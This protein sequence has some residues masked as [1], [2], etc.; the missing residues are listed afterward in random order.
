MWPLQQPARGQVA[1]VGGL[2]TEAEAVLAPERAS[3]A[4]SFIGAFTVLLREGLEALLVVIAMIAF[5][6]K[7]E[8]L[9]EMPYV[10]GGWITALGV[11]LLT[12]AAATYVIGVS[13]ASREL[14]EGF[15]SLFAAVVLLSVGIWMHGKSQADNWQRY[16]REKMTNALS[17]RS[18]WFLFGLTF[19]VVYR[20]AFETIL[21]YAT[22]WSQGNRGSVL[23]GAGAAAAIL[24]AI[25][26]LMLRFSRTLPIAK[27][28]AYSSA[29]IAVLAVVLAGK[30]V[31]ALQEAGVIDVKPLVGI[32]RIAILGVF[33][34]IE[35]VF[36]QAATFAIIALAFW[37]NQRQAR[38][39]SRTSA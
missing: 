23:A 14:T 13:G 17:K 36:A 15:G 6:R 27:F 16:I 7:A 26:G 28:F 24:G 22:L 19:V 9:G 39:V 10:H 5:L 20:E 38:W 35:S 21:F 37:Y 30:G 2:F 3:N 18:A 25:A 33:P 12:W 29:L 34:T 1:T 8:R 32:P 11:G 4:S 31:S